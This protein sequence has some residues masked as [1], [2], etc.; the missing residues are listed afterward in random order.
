MRLDELLVTFNVVNVT[1]SVVG[2]F[3]FGLV[4]VRNTV[5]M[6][7]EKFLPEYRVEPILGMVPLLIM[8]LGIPVVVAFY[9]SQILVDFIA[10]SPNIWERAAGRGMDNATFVLFVG[11]GSW[12]AGRIEAARKP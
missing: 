10:S 5:A 2:G 12:L 4:I 6:V 3:L 8:L 9:A 11:V 1:T 7:L